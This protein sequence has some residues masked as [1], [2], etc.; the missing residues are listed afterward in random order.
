MPPGWQ[1]ASVTHWFKFQDSGPLQVAWACWVTAV[2]VQCLSLT[3]PCR[4]SW[5]GMLLKFASAVQWNLQPAAGC[6]ICSV[7]LPAELEAALPSGFLWNFFPQLASSW[8]SLCSGC[9]TGLAELY[10]ATSDYSSQQSRL[11][12]NSLLD[13]TSRD[14]KSQQTTLPINQHTWQIACHNV[15]QR[16]S[17]VVLP[18]HIV[19]EAKIMVADPHLVFKFIDL[20]I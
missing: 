12:R 2:A 18:S 19:M 5:S 9:A 16:C 10:P 7:P 15:I 3:V 11:S 20:G 8:W 6:G 13:G 14:F 1:P 17:T 4:C